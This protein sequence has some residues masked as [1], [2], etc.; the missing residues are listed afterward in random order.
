MAVSKS[1]NR[2]VPPAKE[3]VEAR[4]KL[5][6]AEPARLREET[7][8]PIGLLPHGLEKIVGSFRGDGEFDEA[9]KLGAKWRSSFRPKRKSKSTTKK[10]A[11]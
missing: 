8:P 2:I 10:S 9:M 1:Q 11:R 4:L 3:A 7:G 6:E 5:L